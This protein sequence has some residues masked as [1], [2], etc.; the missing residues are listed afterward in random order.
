VE[1]LGGAAIAA[2]P[3]YSSLYG[4]SGMQDTPLM[5]ARDR[6]WDERI[7]DACP[8]KLDL[9]QLAENLRRTPAERLARLQDVVDAF[10]EL[11]AATRHPAR[12]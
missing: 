12:P 10:E 3:G 11:R 5:D 6:T 1:H 2:L 9:S 4:V 8:P 7:L